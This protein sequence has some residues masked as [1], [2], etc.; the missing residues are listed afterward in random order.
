MLYISYF[1]N[2]QSSNTNEGLI[3]RKEK[4]CSERV[5]ENASAR[6]PYP[7]WKRS[8]QRIQRGKSR[9]F[10]FYTKDSLLRKTYCGKYWA[11]YIAT[12]KDKELKKRELVPNIVKM[13]GTKSVWS[14]R[15]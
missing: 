9:N 15:V 11:K 10:N 13:Q 1:P 4:T 5:K 3:V 7:I 8:L 2:Q 14:V 6:Y 12:V